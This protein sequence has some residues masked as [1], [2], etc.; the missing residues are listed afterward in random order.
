MT[1]LTDLLLA[2]EAT[3]LVLGVSQCLA[4]VLRVA[5]Y[6][7][8]KKNNGLDDWGVHSCFREDPHRPRNTLKMETKN[9]EGTVVHRSG[10]ESAETF[11][12]TTVRCGQ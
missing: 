9:K 5:E 2:C 7:A 12:H 1:P 6:F 3:L 8:L 10:T 4:I 11:F